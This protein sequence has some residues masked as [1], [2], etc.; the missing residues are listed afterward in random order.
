MMLAAAAIALFSAVFAA[1]M[2]DRDSAAGA[3]PGK[4]TH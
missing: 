3:A 2:I 4:G 1:L